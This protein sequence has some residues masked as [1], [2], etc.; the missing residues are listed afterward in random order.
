[1]SEA[2]GRSSINKYA[3]LPMFIGF[4]IKASATT[5]C[6]AQVIKNSNIII[7]Q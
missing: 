5:I 2:E 6:L 1:M 4:W 3:K 7:L